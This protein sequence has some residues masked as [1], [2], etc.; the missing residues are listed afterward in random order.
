MSDLSQPTSF[1]EPFGVVL[2]AESAMAARPTEAVELAGGRLLCRIGWNSVPESLGQ[3]AGR[4]VMLVEAEGV[5]EPLLAAMLPRIDTIA[6]TL[7]LSVVVAL[8]EQAIDVVTGA[9]FGPAVQLLCAP[10][11]ADRVAA[12]AVAAEGMAG[13]LIEER[14]R[15]G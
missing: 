6:R 15:E 8:D 14:W 10:S 2:I 5:A 7:D 12:L 9:L 4:P 13:R 11:L 1:D 3:Q